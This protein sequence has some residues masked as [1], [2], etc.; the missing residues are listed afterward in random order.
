MPSVSIRWKFSYYIEDK[1]T[2]TDDVLGIP[3]IQKP[4]ILGMPSQSAES[5][6]SD[7]VGTTLEGRRRF[8]NVNPEATYVEAGEKNDN[9]DIPASSEKR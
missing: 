7:F 4:M 6:I 5:S 2:A 3:R 9:S 8:R 1:H